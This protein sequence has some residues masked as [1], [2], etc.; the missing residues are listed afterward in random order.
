MADTGIDNEQWRAFLDDVR[1]EVSNMGRVRTKE[2]GLVRKLR[3]KD[4]YKVFRV[5][6][7]KKK[8]VEKF[9]H[10]IVARAF[11]GE[12]DWDQTM[13][14]HKN[15]DRGDNRV[16]NL[17]WANAKSNAEHSAQM[18]GIGL[19][20]LPDTVLQEVRR[21]RRARHSLREISEATGL[22][23]ATVNN[24]CKEGVEVIKIG[25]ATRKK[26]FKLMRAWQTELGE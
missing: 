4:G 1:Y 21:L 8:F 9:V 3:D 11:L 12:P 13:V 18:R 26:I 7:A 20:R 5:R 17:E 19:R 23:L 15:C 2:T 14:N 24:C 6:M 16:E 10:R 25:L 22:S